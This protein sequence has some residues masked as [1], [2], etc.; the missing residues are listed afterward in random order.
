MEKLL[1][2]KKLDKISSINL[3]YTDTLS[4]NTLMKFLN[5]YGDQLEAFMCCGKPK[6][7]EQ[8]WLNVIPLLK[9]TR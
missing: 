1:E 4:E 9:K 6:L 5:K 2:K 7:T 3:G 8:F